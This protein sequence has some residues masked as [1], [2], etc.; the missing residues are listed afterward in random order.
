MILNLP[1]TFANKTFGENRICLYFADWDTS[2]FANFR[3]SASVKSSHR[4]FP[5]VELNLSGGLCGVLLEMTPKQFRELLEVVRNVI[6]LV[7]SAK[8]CAV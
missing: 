4:P 2:E 5:V 8:S 6:P 3:A 7:E 1:E